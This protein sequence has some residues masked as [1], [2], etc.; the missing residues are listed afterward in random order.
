MGNILDIVLS[1]F[2]LSDGPTIIDKLPVGLSSDP[3]ILF[4]SINPM[5]L[6]LS[7]LISS[8]LY[9]T[10]WNLL[11]LNLLQNDIDILFGSIPKLD[12]N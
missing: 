10:H 11:F 2:D 12:T 1:N 6:N 4:Q 8:R 7:G 9:I 5:I 3:I